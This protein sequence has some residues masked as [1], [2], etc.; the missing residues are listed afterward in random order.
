[1]NNN[2]L[3]K[4]LVKK[5]DKG[6]RG[7]DTTISVYWFAILVIISG[8]VIYMVGIIYGQPYDVREVEAE[9]LASNV[10]DCA[11]KDSYFNL[12][13]LKENFQENFLDYCKLN[14]TT[15]SLA[16]WENE[17][18]YV[19]MNVYDFDTNSKISSASEGNFVLKSDCGLNGKKLSVCIN[20]NVYSIDKENKKYRIEILSVV[21][22]T[23]KNV[24]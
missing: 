4:K 9:I 16:E 6:K 12:D 7:S 14:F 17:Q 15:E 21:R 3:D 23:E 5:F 19:E 1:M 24:Q 2:K 13:I 11:F 18:Y 22:K 10:A 20:K 8:A